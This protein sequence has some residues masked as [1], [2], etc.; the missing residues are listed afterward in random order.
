MKMKLQSISVSNGESDA[1]KK[2]RTPR[3][4]LDER[5][6]RQIGRFGERL[7][8]VVGK[9]SVRSFARRAGMAEG[10][11][12]QY[13][14]GRRYPDLDFLAAITSAADVSLLWLAT[15]EGDKRPRAAGVTREDSGDYTRT[16]VDE[17]ALKRALEAVEEA[18]ALA[19][20]AVEP[21]KKAGIVAAVYTAL[22]R[23]GSAADHAEI[24]RL[25]RSM[26]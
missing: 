22:A 10:T 3:P 12:R 25:I 6:G 5:I 21:G 9:E 19:E 7:R 24:M 11:L 16:E 13:L 18:L 17:T 14:S 26:L 8:E 1:R 4:I 15:G 20:K 2:N 23:P